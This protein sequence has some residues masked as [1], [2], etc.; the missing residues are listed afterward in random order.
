MISDKLFKEFSDTFYQISGI[1]LPI[2]KKYLVEN[3]LSKY[4]GPLKEYRSFAAI[5]EQLTSTSPSEVKST[6]ILLINALTTNYSYFFRDIAHFRFL[7]Y[8]LD[9]RKKQE[10]LPV[11]IW[12]AACSSGEELYSIGITAEMAIPGFSQS[13]VEILGT[14]IS[15]DMIAKARSGRYQ[16]GS[17]VKKL[18]SDMISRFFDPVPENEEYIEVSESIRK[19][20]RIERLNLLESFSFSRPF[21]IVFLRN[22]LIYFNN[23]EKELIINGIAQN[24]CD[25]GY[26][27]LG[28]TENTLGLNIPFTTKQY[29]IYQKSR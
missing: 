12:S 19:K 29:S 1:R 14:D 11:R 16:A 28:H 13:E 27:I 25:K 8:I 18:S 2:E 4:I 15:A 22:I 23:Q 3:R 26:L 24:M 7:S 9:T 6:K 5:L 21:D 10:R 20:I 17:M